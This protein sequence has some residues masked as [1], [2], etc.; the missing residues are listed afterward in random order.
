M[1]PSAATQANSHVLVWDLET[2]PDIKGFAAANGHDGKSDEEIRAAIGDKFPKHL[3]H[4]I[5]CIGALI[6]HR[7]NDHW[8]VDSLGAP[9]VGEAFFRLF[10]AVL[11][12][13]EMELFSFFCL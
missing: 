12:D 1:G 11:L 6:A 8:V 13:Q 5:I 2:I 3:Y 4:S 7:D 10:Q 9:H